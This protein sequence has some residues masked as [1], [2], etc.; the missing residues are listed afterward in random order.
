MTSNVAKTWNS[1]LRE[2][3][4][5]PIMHLHEYIRYQ[6]MNW[7]AERCNVTHFGNGRLTPRVKEI[8][9]ENFEVSGGMLVS[10]IN[11]AE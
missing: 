6:M 7:D 9:E 10:R 11:D 2:A 4:E 8:I 1:V 5:Y 3:R